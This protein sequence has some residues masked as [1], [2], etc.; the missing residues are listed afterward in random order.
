LGAQRRLGDTTLALQ[1]TYERISSGLRINKPSD[2][3]ASL[4][5]A[6]ILNLDS[7]VYRQGL[8]NISDGVSLLNI[9]EGAL[10]E[11][12]HI[13]TRIQELAEQSANGVL[14][15]TQRTTINS[16]AQALVAEYSRILATTTFNGQT[17]LNGSL[18]NLTIQAGYGTSGT[19]SLSLGQK[20]Q[21]SLSQT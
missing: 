9:G 6:S 3:A 16:E 20:V 8:R 4:A 18:A 17:L 1:A 12:S 21:Q 19:L 11:L 5:V 15:S 13:V 7:R 14:S 2:D 10:Q